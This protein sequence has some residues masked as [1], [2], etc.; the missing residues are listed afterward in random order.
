MQ[1]S[2]TDWRE[3]SRGL[4]LTAL[5]AGGVTG[6][7]SMASCGRVVP[8]GYVSVRVK[9][10]DQRSGGGMSLMS[11]CLQARQFRLYDI[12]Q[13]QVVAYPFPAELQSSFAPGTIDALRASQSYFLRKGG[14]HTLIV[15]GFAR[16]CAWLGTEPFASPTPG[17]L[18]YSVRGGAFVPM[19]DRDQDIV[20]IGA[21]SASALSMAPGTSPSPPPAPFA[22]VVW[23]NL[24]PAPSPIPTD[25][26]PSPNACRML[27]R[28]L[29][30]GSLCGATGPV[31]NFPY[32]AQ[33]NSGFNF[34]PLATGQKY[35]LYFQSFAG[36]TPTGTPTCYSLD[37]RGVSGGSVLSLAEA[38]NRLSP[39]TCPQG[40][41][42]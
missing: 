17:A 6:A 23:P 31:G 10:G 11:S 3:L 36:P 37:L 25:C 32:Q 2:S 8:E 39:V 12:F 30:P 33:I 21:V 1:S 34:G 5:S 13:E 22:S 20:L 18:F 19:L 15:E 28:N 9:A 27:V 29:D 40:C 14:P 35:L 26:G 4:L 16:D 41:P 38:P 42:L 24:H 7:L